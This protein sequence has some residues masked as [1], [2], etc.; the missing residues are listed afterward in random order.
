MLSQKTAQTNRKSIV[1]FFSQ[2]SVSQNTSR[3]S[4]LKLATECLPL[5]EKNYIKLN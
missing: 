1:G 3:S 2:Q 4:L 5:R